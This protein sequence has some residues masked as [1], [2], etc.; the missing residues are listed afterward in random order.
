MDLSSYIEAKR[1]ARGA[2]PAY[3]PSETESE[4]RDRIIAANLD[5][6]QSPFGYDPKSGGG[7]FQL[8][9][10]GSDDAEFYFM[11]WDKDIARRAKQVIEV[12]KGA[13]E[14]VQ[15]AIVRK[16]IAIIRDEVQGD[17]GWK[18][19]RLGRWVNQSARQADNAALEDFMMQEF[20]PDPRRPR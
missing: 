16:M 4:R 1:R 14:D 5:S 20:F 19:A 11:G 12:R 6:H 3:S 15:Q 8:K 2:A 18:S 17:F 7:L 13:N 9:R 10:V